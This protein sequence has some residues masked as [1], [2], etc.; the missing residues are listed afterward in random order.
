MLFEK[1]PSGIAKAFP[2]EGLEKIGAA[3][4]EAEKRTCGEIWV[5]IVRETHPRHHRDVIAY[6]Q[7]LFIEHGLTRAEGKGGVLLLIAF[8]SRQ[9]AVL[10]DSG[11][12]AN[13]SQDYWS[14]II[15]DLYIAFVQGHYVEGVCLAVR[16]IGNQ[17][18]LYFPISANKINQP[19]GVKL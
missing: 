12:N 1:K 6:A 11:I 2:A 18:A 16:S 3:V 9:I 15:R 19:Q 17:L 7:Q 10:G 4:A 5:A 14:S 8:Y 13:V